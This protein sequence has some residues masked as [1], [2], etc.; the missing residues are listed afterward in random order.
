MEGIETAERIQ[1]GV[2][3]RVLGVGVVAEHSPRNGQKP[4][5][6]SR[7]TASM[8]AGSWSRRP[9]RIARSS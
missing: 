1:K 2:L 6:A 3:H 7:T 4:A 5:R 9:L 8:T